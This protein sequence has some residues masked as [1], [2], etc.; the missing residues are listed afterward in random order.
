[1]SNCSECGLEAFAW[2]WILDVFSECPY[3]NYTE[4]EMYLHVLDA[5]KLYKKQGYLTRTNPSNLAK[6]LHD[7]YLNHFYKLN[8]L[9]H[10]E[11]SSIIR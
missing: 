1:M 10:I 2:N 4:R 11:I 9:P 3:I 7:R 5:I 8:I 6:K